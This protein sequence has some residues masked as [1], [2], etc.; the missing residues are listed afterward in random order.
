[1]TRVLTGGIL[2]NRSVYEIDHHEIRRFRTKHN[3]WNGDGFCYN[4]VTMMISVEIVCINL[5]CV[6]YFQDMVW[7]HKLLYILNPD[8]K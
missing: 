4:Y 6:V 8:K 3:S 7:Q 5:R 2:V 1:M